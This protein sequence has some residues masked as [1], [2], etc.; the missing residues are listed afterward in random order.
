MSQQE[1]ILLRTKILEG[2][3]KAFRQ[4]YAKYNK[5]FYLTCLRYVSSKEDAQDLLQDALVLMHRDLPK[6]DA[7]KGQLKYWCRK[8]VVNVCLQYLRK[9][10]VLRD[11][12]ELG[13][14]MDILVADEQAIDSL[15]LKELLGYINMLPKGYRT[16]FNLYVIDGYNHREIGTMMNIS[17]STSKTQLMKARRMLQLQINKINNQ[18]RVR[19]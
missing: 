2:N 10:S 6:Y 7:S 3:Q 8:V 14:T 9:K 4:F 17:P 13:E 18:V 15:S 16:I 19:V 11:F 5:W 1:D 12:D